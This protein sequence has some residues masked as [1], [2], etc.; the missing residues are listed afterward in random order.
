MIGPSGDLTLLSLSIK[1]FEFEFSLSPHTHTHTHTLS[2]TH[3]H[4]THTHTHTHT[5]TT[6]DRTERGKCGYS[7]PAATCV[8]SILEYLFSTCCRRTA[9]SG[10]VRIWCGHR[11]ACPAQCL[12][13]WPIPHKLRGFRLGHISFF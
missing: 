9:T 11:E 5:H 3:S 10:K 8:P 1:L 6:G 2:L 4:T 13:S 12:Q 7:V